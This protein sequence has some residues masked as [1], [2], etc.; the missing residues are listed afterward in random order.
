MATVLFNAFH[1]SILHRVM[2]GIFQKGTWERAVVVAAGYQPSEELEDRMCCVDYERAKRGDYSAAGVELKIPDEGI[3]KA[4]GFAESL[5]LR[6]MDRVEPG[7]GELAG[8]LPY[9]DRKRLYLKH[10]CYWN[11]VLKEKEISLLITVSPPHVGY[12]YVL[13][14]LCRARKIPVV[15]VNN[16]LQ[17]PGTIYWAE[18]VE[19]YAPD[20]G[21]AYL[22]LKS[23]ERPWK[24]T[25]PSMK[26]A[27]RG[28]YRWMRRNSKPI[29]LNDTARPE[30]PDFAMLERKSM[31]R[32]NWLISSQAFLKWTGFSKQMQSME[33]K[34]NEARR[35]ILEFR[36]RKI[37]QDRYQKLIWRGGLDSPYVYAPLHYQPECTTNPQG[38]IYTE[39]WLMFATLVESLPE[40]WVVVTKE[41]PYQDHRNRHAAYYDD[42]VRLGKVRIL[43]METDTFEL[44][45]KCQAVATI[46]GTVG[47]EALFKG[48]AVLLFGHH[49][50]Q[51]ATGVYS[52]SSVEQVKDALRH[53][54]KGIETPTLAAIRQYMR[55]MALA[56]SYGFI[57]VFYAKHAKPD[58]VEVVKNLVDGTWDYLGRRSLL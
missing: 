13:Y 19:D 22:R 4:L 33:L 32:L 44:V 58:E 39:Q 6:M 38:G 10:V 57:D 27:I 9:E 52:I 54:L 12:D 1:S 28:H 31:R 29:P 51:Y 55:S 56:G 16:G 20:L 8:H 35:K 25:S 30:V 23:G 43:P 3:F 48:K 40:G 26:K 14:A 41:N 53:I 36:C 49:F 17:V 18:T 15:I 11:A 2:E 45:E 46:S 37:L 34:C 7:P 47:W 24:E 5:V 50:Y 42:L 21:E